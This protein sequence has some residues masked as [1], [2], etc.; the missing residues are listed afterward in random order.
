MSSPYTPNQ[1]K[2][3]ERSRTDRFLSGVCGGL[4][5]Y[6]GLDPTLVRVGVVAI[7]LF[8]GV[9]LLGYVIA[10]IVMPE[11]PLPGDIPPGQVAQDFSGQT[12]PP[13]ASPDPTWT[14]SP[15]QP[16]TASKPVEDEVWGA[17]GAPWEQPQ[18]GPA[19]GT[20]PRDPDKS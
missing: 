19:P 8:T 11:E 5:K 4:A 7:S 20:E 18:P 10:W 13:A 9:G 3:L 6:L 1:P 12:Y 17:G 14:P 2:R 16:A 15:G